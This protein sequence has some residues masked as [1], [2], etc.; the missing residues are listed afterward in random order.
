MNLPSR[1]GAGMNAKRLVTVS[2]RAMYYTNR[3]Y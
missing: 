1:K 2:K 3:A